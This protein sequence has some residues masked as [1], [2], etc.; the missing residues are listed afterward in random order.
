MIWLL[1]EGLCVYCRREARFESV[2][3]PEPPFETHGALEEPIHLGSKMIH[4]THTLSRK[5]L[6]HAT[7]IHSIGQ[8]SLGY[9]EHKYGR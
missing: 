6:K 1:K 5:R 2:T 9:W 4:P 3:T 8:I 7:E